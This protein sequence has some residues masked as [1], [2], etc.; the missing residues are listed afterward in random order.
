M[1]L[2]GLLGP[3]NDKEE[4]VVGNLE[5]ANRPLKGCTRRNRTGLAQGVPT[6]RV[7]TSGLDD[8]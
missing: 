5:T 6:G 3:F 2:L 7:L 4:A 1:K 8:P